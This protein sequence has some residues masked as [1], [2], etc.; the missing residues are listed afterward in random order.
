LKRENHDNELADSMTEDE[1]FDY[2][3]IQNLNDRLDI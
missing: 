2:S 3:E 1:D